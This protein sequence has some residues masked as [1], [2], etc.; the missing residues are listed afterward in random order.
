MRMPAKAVIEVG[1]NSIKLLI[2]RRAEPALVDRNEIVRLGEGAAES[3]RLS[4]EAMKRA[5]R[6]IAA[7]AGE[8]RA[9]GCDEILAVATQA[10]RAAANSVEFTAMVEKSCGLA[11]KIITGEEEADLSFLAVS[12]A[13]P[14]VE[15]RSICVFDVGG[16]SSEI[17]TGGGAYRRSVPIGALSLHNELF[18][19]RPPISLE[20]LEAAGER[21]RRELRR[22]AW[23][24]S[25]GVAAFAG[26][27]GTITT[28]SAVALEL[29]PYDPDRATGSVLDRPEIERQIG[30]YASTGV[31]ERAKIKGLNPKRADIILA[32]ACIVRELMSFTGAEKL[33]VLDRGLRYGVMERY[34]G[35]A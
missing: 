13:L 10:V 3:G 16:G 5:V 22:E 19:G 31:D 24:P 12:S 7:M 30:L 4:G 8:A 15:S 27:G 17:V 35:I 21:V 9:F 26:V 28:L 2:M 6:T 1:T 18:D 20:L 11:I 29:D 23:R 14:G 25:V 32:G 33:I 34:F